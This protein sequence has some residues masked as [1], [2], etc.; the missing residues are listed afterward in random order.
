M[1]RP[2]RLLDLSTARQALVRLFQATNYGE[3]RQLQVRESEP[4]LNPAPIVLIDLKL[5][6][7]EGPRPELALAD[8][9]LGHEVCRLLDRLDEVENGEIERISIRAGIPRRLVLQSGQ[10]VQILAEH[11]VRDA[12]CQRGAC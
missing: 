6:T 8:F 7:D 3:I 12:G 4:V 2:L 5:D 10:P 9:T 1:P 11:L